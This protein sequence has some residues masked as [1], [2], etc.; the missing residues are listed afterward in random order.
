MINLESKTL[1]NLKLRENEILENESLN[2]YINC[3][4]CLRLKTGCFDRRI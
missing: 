4:S 1:K 2:H 3:K